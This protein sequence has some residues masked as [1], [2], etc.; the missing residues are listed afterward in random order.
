MRT[1]KEIEE[2]LG[3]V[4]FATNVPIKSII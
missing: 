2:E 3:V 4:A 1:R